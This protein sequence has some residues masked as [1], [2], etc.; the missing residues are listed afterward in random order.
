MFFKM[1]F[2]K[3][4]I[5]KFTLT[6]PTYCFLQVALA[7]HSLE[8]TEKQ[9]ERTHVLIS[10]TFFGN[11]WSIFMKNFAFL[12]LMNVVVGIFERRISQMIDEL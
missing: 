10:M 7:R 9:H 3:L 5:L 8:M 2:K 4:E 11:F 6:C 12:V 1:P